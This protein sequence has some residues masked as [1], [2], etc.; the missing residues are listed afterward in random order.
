MKVKHRNNMLLF[1]P[2]NTWFA[3]RRCL[4]WFVIER[5]MLSLPQE[6]AYWVV[7]LMIISCWDLPMKLLKLLRKLLGNCLRSCLESWLR[8]CLESC[9]GSCSLSGVNIFLEQNLRKS[10]GLGIFKCRTRVF[11]EFHA[12]IW[13]YEQTSLEGLYGCRSVTSWDGNLL[14][15]KSVK[16]IS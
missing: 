2:I 3:T 6:D 4:I 8:S 9:L 16:V 1:L 5:C 14:T 12:Q 10:F 11:C 15:I 13:F 7:I